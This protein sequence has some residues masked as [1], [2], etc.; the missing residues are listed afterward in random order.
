MPS[1]EVVEVMEPVLPGANYDGDDDDD[2]TAEMSV[3]DDDE[4]AEEEKGRGVDLRDAKPKDNTPVTTLEMT[5][6]KSRS[7]T[8]SKS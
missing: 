8:P 3:E 1:V 7:V 2:Q 4:E 5:T 6:T